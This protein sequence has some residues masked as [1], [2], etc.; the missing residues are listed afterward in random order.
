MDPPWLTRVEWPLHIVFDAIDDE[1][2]AV[3]TL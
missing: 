1:K 2:E 3:S